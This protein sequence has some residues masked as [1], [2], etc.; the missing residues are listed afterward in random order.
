MT[1]DATSNRNTA[2]RIIAKI[3]EI[4]RELANPRSRME[5]YYTLWPLYSPILKLWAWWYRCRVG[6]VWLNFGNP[7]LIGTFCHFLPWELQTQEE[8]RSL[9]FHF[10]EYRWT[11]WEWKYATRHVLLFDEIKSLHEKF[12]NEGRRL[13]GEGA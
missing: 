13:F 11:G 9:R 5:K 2:I 7:F 10:V 6:D 8:K 3:K 12:T 4:L 1:G